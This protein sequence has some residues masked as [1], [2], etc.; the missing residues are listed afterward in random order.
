MSLHV[1]DRPAET[2]DLRCNLKTGE[3]NKKPQVILDCLLKFMYGTTKHY[4]GMENNK[5]I[6][7][8]E[9]WQL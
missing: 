7:K 4:K 1:W 6:Y 2:H 8:T 9:N 3:N 5:G